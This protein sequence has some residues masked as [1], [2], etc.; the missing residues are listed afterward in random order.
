MQM[1]TIA[2]LSGGLATRLRPITT[3]MPKS[4]VLV[5]GEPFVGHQLRMLALE[6]FRKAV[7]LCGFLGEEIQEYVGDGSQFGI[8]VRYSFDGE[9]LRGTGGAIR[10]ALPPLGD[11]FMVI[12]G[13]SW[14]PTRHRPIWEFYVTSGTQGLMTVFENNG[15][16]DSSNVIFEEGRILQY[17]KTAKNPAMRFIDY[18]I[19]AF[20]C[21]VFEAWED[22]A[23]FDL[24]AVQRNL[25]E[26]N[27][28]AGHLV[29]ERF[30]EIG[31]HSGLRE[32]DDYIRAVM[33]N[34]ARK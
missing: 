10:K 23:V 21:R 12:Y 15:Q 25:L 32:T 13:D 4:M 14:C 9:T 27:Q 26:Q 24:S 28:L 33:L 31:S 6:G 16:W 2:V 3:R 34:A 17:D 30:Y 22:T 18:G 20:D 1:P 5:A 7:L 19:G 11:R 29:H 8:E